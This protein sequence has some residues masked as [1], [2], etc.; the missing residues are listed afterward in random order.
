MCRQGMLSTH[1]APSIHFHH[2]GWAAGPLFLCRKT[3]PGMVHRTAD[4][5]VS[6]DFLLKLQALAS[7]M[8]LSLLKAHTWPRP[9]VHGRKSGFRAGLTWR[10]AL[11]ALHPWRA[12]IAPY[13]RR[14]G[15]GY[16]ATN[17]S[18][19]SRIMPSTSACA[20]RMRSKGSL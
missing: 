9:V 11:R 12:G 1:L 2:L 7:F 10:S 20:M 3:F 14:T 8:R 15:P 16:C 19:V 5:S 4:P 13:T 17:G 18:M 6:P